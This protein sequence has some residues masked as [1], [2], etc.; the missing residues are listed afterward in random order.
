[1]WVCNVAHTSVLQIAC[2]AQR[3]ALSAPIL[4]SLRK[5]LTSAKQFCAN[6]TPPVWILGGG[7][8]KCKCC[9]LYLSLPSRDFLGFINYVSRLIAQANW[10]GSKLALLCSCRCFDGAPS[11]AEI[12]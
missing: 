6:Y 2:V 8:I 9:V 3:Q 11:Q 12:E 1:V 5:T 4:L 10:N 7:L